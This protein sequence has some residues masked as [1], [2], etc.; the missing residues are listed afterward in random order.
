MCAFVNIEKGDAVAFQR[1]LHTGILFHQGFVFFER[2]LRVERGRV[3]LSRVG[4]IIFLLSHLH[5]SFVNLGLTPYVLQ[6]M[7]IGLLFSSIVH[8]LRNPHRW[9]SV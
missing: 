5:L 6:A 2:Q 4:R 3:C 1:F 9:Q 8:H 7:H